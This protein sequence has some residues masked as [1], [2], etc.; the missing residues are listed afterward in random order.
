MSSRGTAVCVRSI[1]PGLVFLAAVSGNPS[2]A[3][4]AA[5]AAPQKVVT[6]EGIT[7]YRLPNGCRYLLLPDPSSATVTVCMTVLVGSRHEG[8]G[9]TGMAHLLE[10]MLFKGSKAFP[11]PD[12]ALE[13]HGAAHSAN[14]TTWTDRTMYFETMPATEENL[15]FGIAFEADR[16]VHAFLR[17]EDL[18]KEMTV[19]RNEFEMGEN[20]PRRILSQRLL[21]AAYTWHNYGKATIGNRADIERVPIERLRAFYHKYYR[22]DNILLILAGRFDPALAQKYIAESFGVLPRPTTPLET[23]YTEEPPQDGERCVTLRRV[24]KVAVVGAVY[25]TP[26]AADPDYAAVEVLERILLAA[27]AGRLYKALV[28]TKKATAV[29]GGSYAWHDPAVLEVYAQVADG[30]RP[31]EVLDSLL[32]V[33]EQFSQHPATPEEVQ[34]AQ[35]E[36]KTAYERTLAQ[37]KSL[38]LELGEWEAAGDWRLFF[39]H[40]DQVAQVRPADV[41]RVARKYLLRS[42][43][44]SGLF[45]PTPPAEVARAVLSPP[46][47]LAKLLKGYRG[48]QE[49]SAGEHIEPTPAA[50]EARIHR[51]Q[52]PEGLRVAL[53]PKKTRGQKVLALLTL[54]F[55]NERSL[56]GLESAAQL[57]GP[58]MRRGTR[59]YSRLQLED[60]LNQLGATLEA[61]SDLGEL[62][63]EL[64]AQRDTLPAVLDLL[65]E[66]LR[67]PTFPPEEFDI[68]QRQYRQALERDLAEPGPLARNALRRL[69]NPYPQEDVRYVPTLQEAIARLQRLRREQ[70][71]RLYTEQVGAQVGELVLLGDFDPKATLHRFQELLAGWKAAVPYER[72]AY[73][74]QKVPG[75]RLTLHTPDKQNAYYLAGELWTL[76]DTAPDYPALEVGNYILGGGGFTSLLTDRVRQQEGLSYSVF[77]HLSVSSLEERASFVIFAICNPKVID[78]LDQ[79]VHEVLAAALQK[80][81]TTEQLEAAR[82]GLLEQWKVARAN[83]RRLLEQLA[84]DLYLGRTLQFQAELE[85]RIARL[86]AAEVTAALRRYLDPQ[87]LVIIRA[88]DFPHIS[89]P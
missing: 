28:E 65:E 64:E 42:N 66:V 6:V 41:D 4:T 49:M 30:Q 69:L 16:L 83:D 50:L 13:A 82:R 7:E 71:V 23:T 18:E 85:A 25:H 17:R 46:P 34:R 60:Q 89:R 79:V 70:V 73:P 19:V 54:H 33:L 68:L 87:R 61:R 72:I 62:T 52:F 75:Q 36:L 80:G 56:R 20:N 12:K 81:I 21:S 74:V 32:Q 15:K 84:Q 43:R 38:A 59:K 3:Q 8:Y 27:P 48:R 35:R 53:L 40:R 22:P 44:T 37:S 45:L 1:L 86:T 51:T 26:A 9:E 47:D 11:Y 88:G 31:Q 29:W 67:H 5:P 76:K 63:F 78:R 57:L 55:G 77:S 58:L 24:G 14:A 39:W 10:H 2:F